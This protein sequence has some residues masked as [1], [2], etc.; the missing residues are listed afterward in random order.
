M[1]EYEGDHPLRV[2]VVDDCHDTTES[3]RIL[4]SLWGYEVRIAHDGH[5]AL[6]VAAAYRPHAVVLD[7]G[8]PGPNGFQ[9]ARQVRQMPGL[10]ETLLI[11]TTGYGSEQDRGRTLQAGFDC[12]FIKPVD[13]S[14]LERILATRKEILVHS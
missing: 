3:L 13:P 6:A 8:I 2:L 1:H 9:V 10:E 12:H 4:L 14:E 11:A 5:A 7:I